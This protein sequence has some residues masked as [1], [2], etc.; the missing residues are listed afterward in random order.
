MLYGSK[1]ESTA[2][3]DGR[4]RPKDAFGDVRHTFESH[5][6]LLS[7]WQEINQ[8]TAHRNKSGT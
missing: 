6:A 3:T 1:K 4:I 2:E 5:Q 8:V 7:A